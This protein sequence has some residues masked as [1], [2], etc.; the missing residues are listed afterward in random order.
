MC[1]K[2]GNIKEDEHLPFPPFFS[3]LRGCVAEEKGEGETFCVSL[4]GGLHPAAA[5]L[6]VGYHSLPLIVG[7]SSLRPVG[8]LPRAPRLDC[9]NC[10]PLQVVEQLMGRS[11]GPAVTKGNLLFSLFLIVV[12]GYHGSGSRG[13]GAGFTHTHPPTHTLARTHTRQE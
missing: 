5:P 3:F 7:V 12:A 8:L 1:V 10:I 9:G 4:A 11:Q 6:R 2:L 13:W